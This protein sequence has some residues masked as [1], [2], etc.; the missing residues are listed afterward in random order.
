MLTILSIIFASLLSIALALPIHITLANE[1]KENNI[2]SSITLYLISI[3]ISVLFLMCCLSSL[4]LIS[5][6]FMKNK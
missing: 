1:D 2:L 3:I 4:I 5:T 6:K